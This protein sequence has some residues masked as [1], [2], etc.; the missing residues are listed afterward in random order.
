[1]TDA[2]KRALRV[3]METSMNT[4]STQAAEGLSVG[5]TERAGALYA[6]FAAVFLGVVLIAGSGF[7]GSEALHNAAHDSR[8]SNAFPCH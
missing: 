3:N 8:H 5:T 1:M 4:S 6:V 2:R 7:A